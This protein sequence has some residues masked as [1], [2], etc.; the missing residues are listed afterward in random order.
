M[1]ELFIKNSKGTFN[2]T[3]LAEN[4]T[5]SGDY[6]QC[7]RTLSVGLISSYKDKNIPVIAFDLGN[8]I[9]LCDGKKVLFEGF[10][11]E[12]QKDTGS[13]IINITCYDR[14]FYLKRNQTTMKFKNSTP[15]AITKRVC[16]DFDIPVGNVVPTGIKIKRN[17]IGVSLY[18]IIQTA[19][20]LASQK[21]GKKY[22][23]YFTGA[24]LNVIEKKVSK[25][26]LLI[27]S[28]KNLMSASMSES[29]SDMINQVAIYNENDKLIRTLKNSEQIKLYGVLQ[30]YI[31][32]SKGE[33]VTKDAKRLMS[34]NGVNQ[35]ITVENL[36][37]ISNITGGTVVVREPYTGVYGLFYIDSDAHT[38]QKG[39]YFNNLTLN[40]KNIMDEQEAGSLPDNS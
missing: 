35:R 17:F 8:A 34:D 21:N 39:Q 6:Q 14:G 22:I 16:T 1:I 37:N 10:I 3:Q 33:D 5:W 12:R 13:N 28:G 4:I 7:A 27:E 29:I 11:I 23:I 9:K 15:E 2:I 36:G 30:S 32:Q 25:S 40:F 19:Y 26:T 31:K 20:T 18:Q 38:W 24:E